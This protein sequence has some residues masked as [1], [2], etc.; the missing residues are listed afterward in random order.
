MLKEGG[1]DFNAFG[2]YNQTSPSLNGD[3]TLEPAPRRQL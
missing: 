1:F 3:S 2:K